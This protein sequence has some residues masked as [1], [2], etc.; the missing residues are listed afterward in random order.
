MRFINVTLII[1]LLCAA[2]F[3]LFNRF[4]QKSTDIAVGIIQ[5]ISHP[6]LNEVK[7]GC[8]QRLKEFW[9]DDICIYV[10]NAE[11]SINNAHMIAHNMHR[12]KSLKAIVTI[13]TMATQV[14]CS[15]E[16]EKNIFFSAVTD[17][18]VLGIHNLK[19]VFGVSD[20]INVKKQLDAIQLLVPQ[21]QKIGVI[22]NPAEANSVAAIPE[23]EHE[24][25]SRGYNFMKFGVNNESEMSLV[26]AHA[27]RDVD[28]LLLPADNTVASSVQIIIQAAKS[29]KKPVFTGDRMLVKE[30]VLASA[31][32]VDYFKHGVH[33]ADQIINQVAHK[34]L[35]SNI[36]D[37]NEIHINNDAV[38]DLGIVLP[39]GSVNGFSI[40]LCD[41]CKQKKGNRLCT[42]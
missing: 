17:S 13:G 41:T 22:F 29:V 34:Q 12:N 15:V 14:T 25:L 40:V 33:V 32:G 28:V 5:T 38:R 37:D 20:K 18:R 35:V 21:A 8:I 39:K 16:R 36:Q 27:C 6:S 7:N 19:N 4:N 9:G 42:N 30:G 10:K 23:I 26:A 1:G 11:G 3:I 24:I 2:I 31:G